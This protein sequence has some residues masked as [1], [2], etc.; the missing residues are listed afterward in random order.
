MLWVQQTM[1]AVISLDG[2]WAET[3]GHRTAEPNQ[4]ID[5]CW[6]T[7]ARLAPGAHPLLRAKASPTTIVSFL[8]HFLS[9]F[10][11]VVRLPWR[12]V[13]PFL[14]SKCFFQSSSLS[15]SLS[16]LPCQFYISV[17]LS[18]SLSVFS[19]PRS[20]LSSQIAC[21]IHLSYIQQ[22]FSCSLDFSNF[23]KICAP[24]SPLE[25]CAVCPCEGSL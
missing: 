16:P 6:V 3:G 4:P 23:F 12:P 8:P 18:L 5:L 14:L 21:Y 9:Y 25:T 20:F 15:F 10:T 17:H 1:W 24:S 19:H 13:V 11:P 2:P 7:W 22:I